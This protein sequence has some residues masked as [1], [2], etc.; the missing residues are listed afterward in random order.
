VVIAILTFNVASLY[1][2]AFEL[3]RPSTP[4]GAK[5][6]VY[7]ILAA[8]IIIVAITSWMLYR[9]RAD[10]RP[11]P[12]IAAWVVRFTVVGTVLAFVFAIT[13]LFYP[14]LNR[15]VGFKVTDIF[16]YHQAGA[17]TL[18]YAVM[19]IFQIRSRNWLEIRFPSVMGLTFNGLAFLV[20]LYTLIVGESLLLPA[21]VAVASLALT[22]GILV[23]M[24]TRGG[25]STGTQAAPSA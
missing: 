2:C 5:P 23:V 12:D 9:H 21:L 19:G 24:R 7:L 10:A 4:G 25:T 16:L 20:S 15:L 22:I 18:G 3:I 14:Q 6:V 11:A 1:V 13:P 17:G 8:S